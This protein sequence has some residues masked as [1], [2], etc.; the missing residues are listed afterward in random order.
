MQVPASWKAPLDQGRLLVV[1]PFVSKHRRPTV[2]LAEQRNRLVAELAAALFIAH[3]APRSKTE[4]F[5]RMLEERGRTLW[6]F[7]NPVN[8]LLQSPQVCRFASADAVVE[9]GKR[10][11]G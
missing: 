1:S 4:A 6:S 11:K 9:A 8:A 3:A 10:Q 7:D 2:V 5:S